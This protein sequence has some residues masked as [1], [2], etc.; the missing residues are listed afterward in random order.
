MPLYE[1]R[2][3][4]CGEVTEV[5]QKLSDPP[6]RRCSHCSG[7]VEKLISRTSFQLKGGGWY[8]HGYGQE[9]GAKKSSGADK[10]S[11]AATGESSSA[12]G[13]TSSTKS[14]SKKKDTK[15]EGPASGGGSPVK[16]AAG[17]TC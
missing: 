16:A 10:T 5:L 1:Y 9:A 15:S 13:E 3:L 14:S 17:G 11:E 2:C 4:K 12:S 7:K 8:A 6:L